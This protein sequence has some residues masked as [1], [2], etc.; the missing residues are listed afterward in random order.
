MNEKDL[1]FKELFLIPVEKVGRYTMLVAMLLM[2]LP[3]LY[4]LFFHGLAPPLAPLI[5][6]VLAVWSFGVIISVIEPVV[7]YPILGFGGTYMSFLVGNI[8]NLRVPVSAT[9]Q[10]VVGTKEGT[11]E[12]EIVSTLGIAGSLVASQLVMIVGVLVFLPFINKIQ[13][14]GGAVE[15]A[16]NQVL[17]AL[18]GGLGGAFILRTPKLAVVPLG[19]AFIIAF[20]KN[21]LPISLVIPPM[22]VISIVSARLMYKKGW[23]GADKTT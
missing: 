22:V 23:V 19:I 11:P 20:L 4:L 18:F 17:P 10:Q 7:Y 12:A 5:K 3:G 16:L 1:K 6:G 15:E 13:G 9:S 2:Q 21:D 14:S 8:L